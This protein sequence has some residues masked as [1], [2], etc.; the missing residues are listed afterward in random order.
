VWHEQ[1]TL[2][3][4]VSKQ[5]QDLLYFWT[6]II[7]IVGIMDRHGYKEQKITGTAM[8][9]RTQNVIP[10]RHLEWHSVLKQCSDQLSRQQMQNSTPWRSAQTGVTSLRSCRMLRG[11]MSRKSADMFNRCSLRSKCDQT[12]DLAVRVSDYWSWGPGFDSRFCMGIL[13]WRG[14]VWGVQ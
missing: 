4:L 13:P 8:Y 14:P 5:N 2:C 3:S 10:A 7:G 1:N 12:R 11:A 9:T 6:G